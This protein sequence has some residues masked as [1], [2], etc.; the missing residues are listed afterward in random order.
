MILAR[1]KA[2]SGCLAEDIQERRKLPLW[3]Q[4]RP[5][6][7]PSGGRRQSFVFASIVP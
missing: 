3:I 6:R 5:L 2:G 7:K 1:S 4:F